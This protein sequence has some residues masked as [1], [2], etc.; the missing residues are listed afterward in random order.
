MVKIKICGITRLA[1]AMLASEL[2]AS[3]VGFVF[4]EQSPRVIDP[5]QAKEIVALLPPDVAP[6]GVF[7]DAARDWVCEV[8]DRVNLS[9]VQLH[10]RESVEYCQSLPCRVIKAVPCRGPANIATAAELPAEIT[11]LLDTHDPVRKGGTGRTVDWV[12]ASAAA[13]L[14]RVFLAGGLGPDNVAEAIN[15]VRPYAVDASSRLETV[16]GIKDASKVRAFFEAVE[17]LG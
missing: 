5:A 4:W 16:P 10:G 8:V 11:V 13:R 3:A 15:K 14:R 9:A 7:V 12:A 6:V 2:G 17:T 1:D